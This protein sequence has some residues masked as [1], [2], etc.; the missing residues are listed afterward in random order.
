MYINDELYLN[1]N[2]EDSIMD[3][4]N[5]NNM[6]ELKLIRNQTHS[7]IQIPLLQLYI[8]IIIIVMCIFHFHI[9]R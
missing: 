2:K 5:A 1:M 3:F 9:N 4:I 6:Q 8:E 7:P